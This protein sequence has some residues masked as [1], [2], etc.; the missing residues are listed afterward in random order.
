MLKV[1]DD[2]EIVILSDTVRHRR[3]RT[4]ISAI[5]NDGKSESNVFVMPDLLPQTFKLDE[6]CSLFSAVSSDETQSREVS[7]RDEDERCSMVEVKERDLS[8]KMSIKKI[9]FDD[10]K[11]DTINIFESLQPLEL[12]QAETVNI[13]DASSDTDTAT[14][15]PQ[16]KRRSLKSVASNPGSMDELKTELKRE[17][18][19]ISNFDADDE[20]VEDFKKQRVSYEGN[21][22]ERDVLRDSEIAEERAVKQLKLRPTLKELW[23]EERNSFYELDDD[24][25]EPLVFSDDEEIPRYSIEMDSDSDAVAAFSNNFPITF[26]SRFSRETS[27][28]ESH[29]L[30][31]IQQSRIETPNSSKIEHK[32]ASFSPDDSF[33]GSPPLMTS[34]P[35][36]YKSMTPLDQR[37]E[38]F[39][40]TAR[41]M[42][43]KLDQTLQQIKECDDDGANVIEHMKL[44]IAPD[45]ALILSQGDT[46]ILETHG[47]NANL[48]QRL[49]TTQKDLRDKYKDVQNS[50]TT[51][52]ISLLEKNHNMDPENQ[53]SPKEK[54]FADKK[55][56]VD[57]LRSS[58]T[59]SIKL[60][61]LVAKVLK[62]VNDLISKSI[63]LSSEDE[64]TKRILDIGVSKLYTLFFQAG[65]F[66]MRN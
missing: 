57:L 46:L 59:S 29:D 24:H 42:M 10:A 62:R 48:T 65:K 9:E 7:T 49:L 41:Y 1:D 43:K 28:R 13:I 34:S 56:P 50:N 58:S 4:P 15:T 35:F 5:S 19:T 44:S 40:K 61:D 30:F 6:S 32:E 63:D 60:E 25:D 53:Y 55:F 38:Q 22:K 64:L 27:R 39:E 51:S 11:V 54:I 33:V 47:K 45:A 36:T 23:M 26:L 12:E 3:S 16:T 66:K 37:V 20:P 31:L 18:D 52:N 2:M 21:R 17:L 14:S 8:I